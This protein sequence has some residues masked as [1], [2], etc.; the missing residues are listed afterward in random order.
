MAFILRFRTHWVPHSFGLV[1]NR[2]KDLR[3]LL[4]FIFTFLC[5]FIE[6]FFSFFFF[7]ARVLIEY[8][9]FFNNFDPLVI[10]YIRFRADLGLMAMKVCFTFLRFQEFELH[11]QIVLCHSQDTPFFFF[12]GILSSLPEIQS[13]Y[14]RL[15][16]QGDM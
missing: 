7:F 9:S 8:E 13:A 4:R 2:S 5:S 12:V 16:R 14:S 11:N 3:K 15:R 1:L 6:V 10:L